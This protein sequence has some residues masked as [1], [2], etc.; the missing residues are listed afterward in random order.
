M[1]C[2][3]NEM[4]RQCDETWQCDETEAL[5]CAPIASWDT[6]CRIAPCRIAP[7]RPSCVHPVCMLCGSPALLMPPSSCRPVLYRSRSLYCQARVAVYQT[8]GTAGRLK[9]PAMFDTWEKE[10]VDLARA[11]D[12]NPD[13]WGKLKS[14][15]ALVAK[16]SAGASDDAGLITT[17]QAKLAIS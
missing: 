7:C 3:G 15:R 6:A 17:T 9:L 5:E 14:Q 13:N 16:V 2:D 11:A 4:R 12:A 8:Y 10:A 1:K